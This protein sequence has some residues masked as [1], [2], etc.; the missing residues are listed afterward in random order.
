MDAYTFWSQHLMLVTVWKWFHTNVPDLMIWKDTSFKLPLW[1]NFIFIDVVERVWIS[2]H[3]KSKT[4]WDY[5]HLMH[6]CHHIL[7]NLS[8]PVDI[9]FSTYNNTGLKDYSR[10]SHKLV[11]VHCLLYS[12]NLIHGHVSPLF[13]LLWW[14]ESDK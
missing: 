14:S 6:F 9:F 1:I 4:W 8:C 2:W 5:T 3:N 12:R 10:I 7:F 13:G 11:F